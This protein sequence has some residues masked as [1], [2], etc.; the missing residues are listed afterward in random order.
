MQ[1]HHFQIQHGDFTAELVIGGDCSLYAFAADD[2]CQS[3]E[4]TP[5]VAAISL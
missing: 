3:S 4:G 2:Y 1:E 5:S